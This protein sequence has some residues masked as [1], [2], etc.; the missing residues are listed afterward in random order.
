M[1]GVAQARGHAWARAIA[2]VIPI[3]RPWPRTERMRA[4]AMRKVSDLGRDERLLD[5]LAD[6]CVIGAARWW[7]RELAAVG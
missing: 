2:A 7:N 5:L 3:V 4:I 6:E 1:R